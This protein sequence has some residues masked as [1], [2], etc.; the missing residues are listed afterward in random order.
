MVFK[1]DRQRKA[2]MAKLN[3]KARSPTSPTILGRLRKRFRPTSEEL[4]EQRGARIKREGEALKQERIT[5]EQ[6]ELE[7]KL[8]TER[9]KLRGRQEEARA[10]LS[11]IDATRRGKTLTGRALKKGVELGKIGFEKFTKPA[12]ARKRTKRRKAPEETGFFGI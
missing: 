12:P 6:L 8:E 3:E 9:E 2:V 10:R 7:S 11:E 4:A 1:S 5:A